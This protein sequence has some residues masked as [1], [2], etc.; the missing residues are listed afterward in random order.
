MFQNDLIALLALFEGS[1]TKSPCFQLWLCIPPR[2]V[3]DRFGISDQRLHK[4]I[5]P[6]ILQVAA[7]KQIPTL[8]MAAA[9]QTDVKR[10][11]GVP[12]KGDGIH[13]VSDGARQIARVAASAI[14]DFV[15]SE[16]E[17]VP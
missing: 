13:P 12:G 11:F 1:T 5:A 10:L 14:K 2:A 16:T 3:K 6:I 7:K 9:L 8:D 4:S 17:A 15:W